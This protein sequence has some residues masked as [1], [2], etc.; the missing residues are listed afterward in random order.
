[1]SHKITNIVVYGSNNAGSTNYSVHADDARFND[2]MKE[3]GMKMNL[4]G[5][6]AG[7]KDKPTANLYAPMDIEGGSS[8]G[9]PRPMN[10]FTKTYYYPFFHRPQRKRQQILCIRFVYRLKNH[11]QKYDTIFL[12]PPPPQ[13]FSRLFPPTY[14]DRKRHPTGYLYQLFRPEFVLKYPVPL[15]SDACSQ[16]GYHDRRMHNDEVKKATEYLLNVVVP[17]YASVI[18]FLAAH[19]NPLLPLVKSI[20]LPNGWNTILK[21]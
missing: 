9:F 8:L 14:P 5:H 1:M 15:S 7:L 10:L 6:V 13:D 4:K 21:P 18:L 19:P 2:L 12:L 17:G 11:N 20:V 3:A 16:F